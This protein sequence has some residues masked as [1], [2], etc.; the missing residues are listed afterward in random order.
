MT[1]QSLTAE[2]ILER[3]MLLTATMTAGYLKAVELAKAAAVCGY[4]VEILTGETS[5]ATMC[6]INCW[7]K[8]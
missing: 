1:T 5:Y 4:H 3:S 6:R 7:R 8:K 2:Q